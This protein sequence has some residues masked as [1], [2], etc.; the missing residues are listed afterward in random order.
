MQTKQG[1]LPSDLVIVQ[2]VLEG[3]LSFN[4]RF[5]LS[6]HTGSVREVCRFPQGVFRASRICTYMY[7]GNSIASAEKKHFV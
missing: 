7:A 5:N 4:L 3:E 1:V 2:T 6:I